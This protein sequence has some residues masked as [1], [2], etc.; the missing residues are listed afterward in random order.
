[1]APKMSEPQYFAWQWQCRT[2]YAHALLIASFSLLSRRLSIS[3]PYFVFGWALSWGGA[4]DRYLHCASLTA[5]LVWAL[6]QGTT[7][8]VYIWLWEILSFIAIRFG[9]I[10]LGCADESTKD[11]TVLSADWVFR[12]L[13]SCLIEH[14]LGVVPSLFALC[15]AHWFTSL[16]TLARYAE[17][18]LYLALRNFILHCYQVRPHSSGLR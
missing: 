4:F 16:S 14:S 12:S 9:L 8:L 11:E 7:S 15:I 2:L 5:L 18:R 17:T 3:L 13:T 1:M 6:W 10:P